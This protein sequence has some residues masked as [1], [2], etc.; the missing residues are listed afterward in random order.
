MRSPVAKVRPTQ[1]LFGIFA[2]L[3]ICF[4]LFGA[5]NGGKALAEDGTPYNGPHYVPGVIQSEDFN[6]GA[7]SISCKYRWE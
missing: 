1:N 5:L 3:C 7:L 6:S 2:L 4:T